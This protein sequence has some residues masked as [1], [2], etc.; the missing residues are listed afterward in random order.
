MNRKLNVLYIPHSKYGTS[1]GDRRR[2]L[3]FSALSNMFNVYLEEPRGVKFDLLVICLGGDLIKATR[4][5]DS[6]PR[7]VLDYTNHYLVEKSWLKDRLRNQANSILGGKEWSTKAYKKTILDLMH[8]S[9]LVICPSVTQQIHLDSIGIVSERITD[10]FEA[11]VDKKNITF[12]DSRSLFW[13]GQANNIRGLDIVSP[14]LRRKPEILLR[15]VTDEVYGLLGGQFFCRNTRDY[16]QDHFPS[17]EFSN[18]SMDNVNKAARNS[19]LG[20]I[21]LDINDPF[22]AAKPENKLVFMWLLGLGALCSPTE[23]YEM[24]SKQTGI[25]FICGNESQWND[26]IDK[27]LS[28]DKYREETSRY[29]HDYA[30]IHYCNEALIKKWNLALEKANI[31]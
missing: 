28:N 30:W 5:A 31:F 27:L 25:D 9:D 1:P 2:F 17:F 19:S 10:F 3:G 6:I 23:S 16:C 8:R 18:W 11:E 20:I 12:S 29:L 26:S 7:V 24:L 4:L 13:E 14:T 21:P 22:I 15:I